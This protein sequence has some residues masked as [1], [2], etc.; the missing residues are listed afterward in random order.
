[1]TNSTQTPPQRPV[2]AFGKGLCAALIGGMMALAGPARAADTL[3]DALAGAYNTSGLLE[4]NRALLRAA[5]EDVASTIARLRPILS[6]ST[7]ITRS[8]SNR[9]GNPLP[10]ANGSSG[11]TNLNAGI[12]AEW[13]IYDFGRTRLSAD[14][15]KEIVLSTRQGLVSIEQQVLLRAVQAYMNVQRNTRF[16]SL[17]Q[18]NVRVISESLRAARD[19]FEVGEV[20]RTDVAQAEARLSLSRSSLAQAVGD[21]ER[22]KE[23]YRAVV[24]NMPGNLSQPRSI[25]V[26]TRTEET[27]KQ[28]ALRSHPDM[29]RA[30]HDVAAA[31][32]NVLVAEGAMKPRVT[33]NASVGVNE[34]LDGRTAG[35]TGSFG[36]AIGG[37]I[38]QGGALASAKRRAFAQA[39]AQLAILHQTQDRIRQNVGNAYAI[40]EAARASVAASAEAVRA[41]RV[42]FEGVNEEATLGARTTLDVLNAEQEYLDAQANQISAQADVIIA[43]YAVLEAMGELTVRDLNLAVQTYD[44]AAYYNLV[45]DAPAALSQRGQT[46]DRVLRKIGK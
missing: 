5:D 31:K 27:A 8:Y 3:A 25:P 33:L 2:R 28:I 7:D 41:G 45:K 34:R 12:T 9:S 14:A 11:A 16:V 18:S 10:G 44:P 4:Q 43:S 35:E 24:G 21:L 17:R 19:R 13:L 22:A 32:L 6:W 1:M 38:Y 39:D 37:P 20:T 15:A 23:E 42:A 46:L 26:L 30:Q 40:L 36:V 29:L